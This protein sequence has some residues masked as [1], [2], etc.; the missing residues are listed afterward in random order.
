MSKGKKILKVI[1]NVILWLVILLAALITIISIST[2][3][4]GVAHIGG[5]MMFSIQTESMQPEIMAGDLIIGKQCDPKELVVGDIIS[6]FS[7][8]QDTTIIKTHRIIEIIDQGGILSFVTK[9]DNNDTADTVDVPIGDV[10][11][12]YDGTKIPNGGNVLDFIKSQVGFFVCIIVPLFVFFIYQLYRFIVIVVRMKQE[13][14][15][16]E[17]EYKDE[18][19]KEEK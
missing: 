17:Q 9:G 3:D 2:R 19:K 13:Q 16:R 12:I 6:F 5:M 15:V 8:E 18:D 10:V 11:A 4:R 14:A 1:V 7:I